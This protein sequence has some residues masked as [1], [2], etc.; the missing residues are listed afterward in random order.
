MSETFSK[1]RV[2]YAETDAMGVAHH[3][4]FIPWFEVA[5]V[6]WLRAHDMDYRELEKEGFSL[7][8]SRLEVD[9]RA[10]AYF[11]DEITVSAKMTVIKSRRVTFAYRAIRHDSLLLATA[12][13]EHTPTARDGAAI[14]LPLHWQ[15]RLK[16]HATEY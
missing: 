10:S 14:R 13:S 3:G 16:P 8:V 6:D 11:D 1:L 15:Q 4:S 9:Y 7:A 5:R 12:L 2:R